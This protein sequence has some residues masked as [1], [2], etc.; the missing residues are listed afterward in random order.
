MTSRAWALVLAGAAVLSCTEAIEPPV[1][2]LDD[3]ATVVITGGPT[4]VVQGDV[5]G[6]RAEARNAAGGTVE[7]DV[8]WRVA[9]TQDGLVT[10]EGRFVGFTAGPVSVIA[11]AGSQADTVVVSVAARNLSGTFTTVGHGA[12]PHRFTSDLW[13]AGDVA[14]TGTW[15]GRT[16]AD[17][18]TRFGNTLYVW[19]ISDPTAPV[20]T[21][22]VQ[23]D[24]RVVNDVKVRAA[25]DLAVITH[26]AS[27]DNLN[28]VTL[29]DLSDP[30]HP[31]TI[32]RFTAQL[33]SGVHNT[34]IDGN[35][36]YLA[37]DGTGSG[38]RV[39]DVSAPEVPAVVGQFY[40]GT[41]FLHD[42]YVRGGLA[43]LSHWDAGLV[44]LDV[45]GGDLGGTPAA[46]VELS[47]VLTQGG[48]T[49]N[50]WYWPER[51]LVF[52]GE[53]DFQ[54]PGR[55]HVVDVSD[56][57]NPVEVASFAVAGAPPHNF[58]LDE[59]NTVLHLAWYSR[60]IVALDVSGEL[61][62]PLERQGREIARFTYGGTGESCPGSTAVA[63]CTWAPQ[64]H[65]GLVWVSDMNT[66]LWSLRLDR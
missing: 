52:V 21:D 2:A 60:G 23:V 45:G 54:T 5:H 27:S 61:L 18:Q 10:P 42:V 16:G 40:A 28:G 66:G 38:L 47:R 64:L 48:E 32:T 11:E 39:L 37:V 36:V 58:W 53:E 17:Q 20:L 9:P 22:S 44:I 51:G 4:T 3:I 63:T 8:A 31:V 49:H 33:A 55:M 6:Y 24:A 59:A 62:G 26:E 13:L 34:W 25:G 1:V 19:N 30:F 65:R 12:M 35:Y 29:L 15:G 57:R 41:S 50:A 56:L 7:T 43:F 14:Y 46:P